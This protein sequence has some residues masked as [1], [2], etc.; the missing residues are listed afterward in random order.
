MIKIKQQNEAA[1]QKNTEIEQTNTLLKTQISEGNALMGQYATEI[2]IY[3]A[4]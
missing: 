3:F 1:T 4:I 2:S